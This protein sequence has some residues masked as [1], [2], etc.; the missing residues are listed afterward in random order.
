M[1]VFFAEERF[2]KHQM[3]G[4]RSKND[5]MS[6]SQRIPMFKKMVLSTMT[7]KQASTCLH[8]AVLE[9]MMHL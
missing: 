6:S 3:L 8:H 4:L 9:G 2:G 5:K 7:K 1:D